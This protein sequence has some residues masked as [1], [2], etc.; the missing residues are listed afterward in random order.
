MKQKYLTP[1]G[2]SL[3]KSIL[4]FYQITT[5]GNNKCNKAHLFSIGKFDMEFI[6][7]QELMMK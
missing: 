7:T 1:L 4:N 3:A 2:F 6:W 5:G